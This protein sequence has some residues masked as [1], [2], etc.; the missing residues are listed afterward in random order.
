MQGRGWA[1]PT[2]APGAVP[3]ELEPKRHRHLPRVQRGGVTAQSAASLNQ[4]AVLPIAPVVAGTDIPV[5]ETGVVE[6]VVH[7][8]P[9]HEHPLLVLQREV[10]GERHVE[11]G[12]ARPRDNDQAS[13]S[14]VPEAL[15]VLSNTIVWI[16]R[17]RC[18]ARIWNLPG[19]F[20]DELV[21]GRPVGAIAAGRRAALACRYGSPA[22]ERGRLA[23]GGQTVVAHHKH[24]GPFRHAGPVL[25][26]LVV[27]LVPLK[28]IP[29]M[30]AMASL[31]HWVMPDQVQGSVTHPSG[32]KFN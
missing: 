13:R 8:G 2:P 10:L 30:P 32:L 4:G 7:L 21:A 1:Y 29:G 6:D 28:E 31:R 3:L 26:G 24:P 16:R 19:G 27:A 14:G 23:D 17:G 15:H 9:E 5:A 22:D 20:V 12:H 11:V 25:L 18:T